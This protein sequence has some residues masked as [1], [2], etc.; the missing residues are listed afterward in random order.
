MSV[1]AVATVSV[2]VTV[3]LPSRVLSGSDVGFRVE[4]R[5]SETRIDNL[6]VGREPANIAAGRFVVRL[7]GEWVEGR[8][9]VNPRTGGCHAKVPARPCCR[10]RYPPRRRTRLLRPYAASHHADAGSHHATAPDAES[11]RGH[12]HRS[13]PGLHVGWCDVQGE[14]QAPCTGVEAHRGLFNVW[15]ASRLVHGGP[16][17]TRRGDIRCREC[18]PA[19]S[20]S[21]QPSGPATTP[22]ALRGLTSS[23]RIGVLTFPSRP[24]HCCPRRVHQ[25]RGGSREGGCHAS[26]SKTALETR[27]RLGAF[28]VRGLRALTIGAGAAS[29][30][31]AAA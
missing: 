27:H 29:G 14:R 5:K 30:R 26:S 17:A 15:S 13:R 19:R 24:R 10:F 20:R 9:S 7:N 6:T 31:R 3:R 28:T 4:R 2:V 11:I 18:Q 16:R 12:T 23:G 8:E 25:V 1:T 21:L 22:R